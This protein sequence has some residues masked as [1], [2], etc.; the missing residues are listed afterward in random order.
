M[1]ATQRRKGRAWEQEVARRLRAAGYDCR[2]GAQGAGEVEPDIVTGQIGATTPWIECGHGVEMSGREKLRQATAAAER[3]R[4][5]YT[6]VAFTRRDRRRPVVTLT[7]A[8]LAALVDDSD[9]VGPLVVTL[10]M[11]DFLAA[12]QRPGV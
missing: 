4:G 11:E 12:I 3:A 2:R 7:V 6:P 1:S 8:G 5:R 9:R 10:D